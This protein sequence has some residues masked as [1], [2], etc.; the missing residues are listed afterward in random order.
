MKKLDTH[1]G[2]GRI[3]FTPTDKKR[4]VKRV[5]QQLYRLLLV[6]SE[7]KS[8]KPDRGYSYAAI[9]GIIGT[10]YIPLFNKND[11]TVEMSK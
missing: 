5:I 8:L 1:A 3:D 4:I 11:Y 7:S 9:T 6:L 10:H 2:Y